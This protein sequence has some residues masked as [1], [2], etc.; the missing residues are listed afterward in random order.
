LKDPDVE[1]GLMEVSYLTDH[2]LDLRVEE[3]VNE[4]ADYVKSWE[5]P[6][7]APESAAA[8]ATD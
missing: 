4:F 7:A 2:G 5:S 1:K 6:R 3:M 8:I